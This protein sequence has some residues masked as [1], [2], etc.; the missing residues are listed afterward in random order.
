[1]GFKRFVGKFYEYRT[2]VVIGQQADIEKLG[3]EINKSDKEEIAY[4]VPLGVLPNG[5]IAVWIQTRVE[6][7]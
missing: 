2:K 6:V 3:N 4:V 7:K 5:D 1:M